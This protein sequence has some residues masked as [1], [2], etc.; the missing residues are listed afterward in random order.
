MAQEKNR[1]KKNSTGPFFVDSSC[2]DCGSC[3]QIDPEHFGP[4]EDTSYVHTQPNGKEEIVFLKNLN[5]DGSLLI[6]KE[7]KEEKIYS[8]R[9]INDFN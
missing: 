3:W 1:L 4:K 9:I 7:G 8:A 6:E 2:I 5:L